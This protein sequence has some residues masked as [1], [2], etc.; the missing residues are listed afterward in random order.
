MLLIKLFKLFQNPLKFLRQKR[1]L[2]QPNTIVWIV[3]YYYCTVFIVRVLRIPSLNVFSMCD[4]VTYWIL[5]PDS[6]KYALN[7]RTLYYIIV[8][9]FCFM[10]EWVKCK[11]VSLTWIST[12]NSFSYYFIK[13][14]YC[15][16]KKRYIE[17]KGCSWNEE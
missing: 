10:V 14:M 4:Q 9:T 3:L 8:Y 2:I 12:P 11:C 1:Y 13:T 7:V 6:V 15:R 5:W 16:T 17:Q